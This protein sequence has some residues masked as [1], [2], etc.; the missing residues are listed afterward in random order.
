MNSLYKLLT[1]T[2]GSPKL[3]NDDNEERNEERQQKDSP[4]SLEKE[5]ATDVLQKYLENLKSNKAV[6]FWVIKTRNC[7]YSKVFVN[8]CGLE[9]VTK[10]V[11]LEWPVIKVY[12]GANYH[13]KN[14][15]DCLTYDV[16][17]NIH[18]CK[19]FAEIHEAFYDLDGFFR[20]LNSAIILEINR[21]IE[22]DDFLLDNVNFTFP[23]IKVSSIS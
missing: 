9:E 11:H 12:A 7:N 23:R 2:K 17:M 8:V 13:D 4:T 3:E 22:D 14:E 15:A 21:R 16:I 19:I 6:P 20:K 5:K 18:D 1:P 10:T